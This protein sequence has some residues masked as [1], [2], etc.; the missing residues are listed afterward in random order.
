[1]NLE[2]I[3]KLSAALKKKWASG[4]RKPTPASA[5]EKAS[6]TRRENYRAGKQVA[7][8]LSRERAN[9]CI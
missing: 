4:T 6:K 3:E 1:M 9:I 5:Y 8:F 2:K 7:P